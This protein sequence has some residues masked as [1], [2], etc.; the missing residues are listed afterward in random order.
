MEYYCIMVNTGKE[1]AFKKKA[2]ASV[3][4]NFPE[5]E[6]FFFQRIMKTSKGKCFEQPLFPGYVFFQIEKLSAEFFTVLR[7]VKDFCR[8]LRDNTDPVKFSGTALEELKLFINKGE[9]WG[10][11]KVQ[12]FPGKKIRVISGPLLG[13]EGNIYKVNKKRKRITITSS[14]TPDGKHFDLFYEDVEVVE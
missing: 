9:H 1:E 10:I 5:V 6:F 11:S 8:I 2:M 12:F 13:L 4:E 7:Q 14:L 3:K